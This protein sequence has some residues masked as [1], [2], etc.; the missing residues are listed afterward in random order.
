MERHPVPQNIM[1][2][3]FKL[4]GALTIKQFGYAAGGFVIALLFYFSG[5][6]EL[7]RWIFIG[8]SLIVGL[9]LAVMKINGQSST[10]WIS[11]FIASMFEPQERLWRKTAIIPDILKDDQSATTKPIDEITS[12]VNKRNIDSMPAMPLA[13]TVIPEEEKKLIAAEDSNLK[14]IDEHFNFL[15]NELPQVSTASVNP[16][17]L[18][19]TKSPAN[20]IVTKPT[21]LAAGVAAGQSLNDMVYQGKD[22]AVSFTPMQTEVSRPLQTTFSQQ[23]DLKANNYLK[24][25]ILG[26]NGEAISGADIY[27]LDNR[28]NIIRNSVSIANG[29]FA[30]SSGLAAGDYLVDIK[31]E[32][33]KF[34]RYSVSL[35]GDKVMEI[36]LQAV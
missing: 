14:Q 16:N 21:T 20:P 10:V 32:G 29:S 1:D 15:F 27:I 28:G 9:F 7:V 23:L 30:I 2:V 35:K 13:E 17:V 6:P 19:Q 8:I 31:K 34:P 24:G 36:K 26:S 18:A 5:L 11:H 22:Y 12:L 4:F 33:F 3:E 25:Q